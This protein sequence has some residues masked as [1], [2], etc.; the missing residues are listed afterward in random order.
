MLDEIYELMVRTAVNYTGPTFIEHVYH[1]EK[2]ASNAFWSKP[3][4]EK[5]RNVLVEEWDIK[6]DGRYELKLYGMKFAIQFK[7]K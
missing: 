6:P 5:Q 2:E 1:I 4:F 3:E 7:C